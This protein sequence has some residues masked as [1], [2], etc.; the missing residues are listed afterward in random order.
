MDPAGQPCVLCVPS[1]SVKRS[2]L[3]VKFAL[4]TFTSRANGTI[5]TCTSPVLTAAFFNVVSNCLVAV[6]SAVSLLALPIEPVLSSASAT[7]SLVLPHLTVEEL[8]KVISD[9][10]ST[11]VKLVSILPVPLIVSWVPPVVV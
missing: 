8:P 11:L 7:R 6:L 2:Q 3:A 10:P 4:P 5:E 9:S 1:H